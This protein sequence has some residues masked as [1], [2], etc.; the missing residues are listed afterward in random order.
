MKL[1]IFTTQTNSK[2]RGDHLSQSLDCYTDLADEL[3]VVNGCDSAGELDK[4]RL[5]EDHDQ[6]EYK[7][8]DKDWPK[9]FSWDFIGSQFQRG[10]EACTGDWVI[11]MDLDM[12]FHENDFAEI[13][14]VLEQH[15][16][17]PAVS[18][19]KRQFILPDRFNLKSR[20]IVAVNKGKFGDRI[21]FD[22][23]G[24]GCQPSLDGVYIQPGSV[25]D[26]SIPIWNYECLLK[27]KEQLL[28]DKGRFARA[29]QRH[30]GEYK[31]GGPDDESAYLAWLK[32]VVGRFTKPQ[33]FI[34][35]GAHPKY[36][37]ETIRH[38]KPEQWGYD[39]LG[40]LKVSSYAKAR[41]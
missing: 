20:L 36:I 34:A 33:E 26:I 39:G 6:Y 12:L 7:Q 25:P 14:Q 29:W 13:R 1:S 8:V 30:F 2:Y 10:Y 37:K 22:S 23:G 21:R 17:E 35:W 4:W 19:L 15:N 16:N 40:N 3:L 9:E 41:R 32:M 18:F 24:D 31:L 27:T 5:T 28:E 11:H 38:L